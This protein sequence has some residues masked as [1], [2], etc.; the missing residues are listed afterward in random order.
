MNF[1]RESR[2]L[3]DSALERIGFDQVTAW[4]IVA[5][6]KFSMS[7]EYNISNDEELRKTILNLQSSHFTN[8]QVLRAKNCKET[9]KEFLSILL[10][11]SHKIEVINI[12]ECTSIYYFLFDTFDERD[13]DI[14][15]EKLH[16]LKELIIEACEALSTIFE[17]HDDRPRTKFP[18]LSKE[19]DAR[20]KNLKSHYQEIGVE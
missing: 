10:E 12:E 18:L 19:V 16:Q 11:R 20:G 7:I 3:A 13:G 5:D 4:N 6:D 9:L 15:A 14:D 2:L 8:L 1:N 17:S